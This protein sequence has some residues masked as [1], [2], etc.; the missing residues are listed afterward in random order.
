MEKGDASRGQSGSPQEIFFWPL[1][2]CENPVVTWFC[3]CIS[4]SHS[5]PVCQIQIY[6]IGYTTLGSSVKFKGYLLTKRQ[7]VYIRLLVLLR[8]T[9]FCW[10]GN[11]CKEQAW[12]AYL[13]SRYVQGKG[14]WRLFIWPRNKHILMW[15]FKLWQYWEI[16]AVR[17]SFTL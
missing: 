9:G 1:C 5:E 14:W 15:D 7:I 11:V 10:M 17:G 13:G 2:R 12:L 8:A 3:G 6:V 16:T 4:S